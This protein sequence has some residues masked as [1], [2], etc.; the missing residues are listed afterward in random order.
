MNDLQKKMAHRIMSNNEEY[1]KAHGLPMD[2]TELIDQ[3]RLYMYGTTFL[4][5]GIL[6]LLTG[7]VFLYLAIFVVDNNFGGGIFIIFTLL[8]GYNAYTKLSK[9]REIKDGIPKLIKRK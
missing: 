1:N 4:V 3:T 9:W 8:F 7:L 6:S 5:F 2:K